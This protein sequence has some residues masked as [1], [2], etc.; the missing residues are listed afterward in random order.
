LAPGRCPIDDE[1]QTIVLRCLAKESERRYQSAG[2]IAR[3][4]R[5]YLAG[6][7]IEAKRDSASY[8]LRKH[9]RKYRVH[10]GV[11]AGFVLLLVI[12]TAALW[13]MYRGQ[14]RERQLAEQTQK[15]AEAINEFVKKALVSSDPNQ[16]GQQDT[17]VADAMMNALKQIDA[18]AFKDEPENEAGLRETIAG[19]L[20]GNGRA[21]EAEPLCVQA[22]EIRRRLFKGDH[23]DVAQGLNNLASVRQA[24]GRAAEAEPLYVQ[25]RGMNQR[26]FKGDHPA[27][28]T[29]M[30]NLAGVRQALGRAAEAE[31]LY[32]QALE[33]RQRLYKGDHPDVARGL[34]NLAVVR[35]LL[36]GAA[37][38][39]ALYAQ[40]LEMQQ[41][42]FK[43]D[44][45]DVARSL[46]SLA[47]A[48]LR[49]GR[50]AEAEPLFVRALQMQQRLFKGDHPDMARS[51][52]DLATARSD[53]GRAAEAEP[54][55]VQALDMWQRLFK[56]DHPDV[57]GCMNS[58]AKCLDALGRGGE[59][60]ARCREA[61]AMERRV[62]PP[63][64]PAL[65]SSMAQLG[66]GLVKAGTPQAAAEAEP[67]LRECLAMRE[68]AFAE[69]H[70]QSWLKYN[71]M[72]L[73]GGALAGQGNF[74]QAE[75]LLLEGY[76]SM[77]D[78][79]HVPPPVQAGGDRK[80]EALERIVK[81][82]EAWDA[83]EPGTGKPE[84]AAEYRALLDAFDSATDH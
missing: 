8:M 6:E 71:T 21:A 22:L 48:R 72:S 69:G 81:L 56:G 57:A 12:S 35:Q 40:A 52:H 7:P 67:I 34:N 50:A 78:D 77:K 16:G 23:P 24:L 25:A 41:R 28:A 76:N 33:M 15:R 19:I 2:E 43:G 79:P 30:S 39:E 44:H 42:L 74:T 11:S 1:V 47:N 65:A 4:I 68:K 17:L 62:L 46:N 53:L 73:L 61:L 32:V 49:L 63:D 55:Y 13:V 54:L 37:E 27:V 60:I 10:A 38:A 26:L 29:S 45:P 80:R 66:L 84:K 14:S 3:D 59:A 31:P 20:V 83:T 58:L 5:H 70:P 9:L 51:L 82:Y 64:S 75:P 36:V 18:G